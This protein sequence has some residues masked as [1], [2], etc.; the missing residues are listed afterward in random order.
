MCSLRSFSL[1]RLSVPEHELRLPPPPLLLPQQRWRDA[2]GMGNPSRWGSGE[3]PHTAKAMG[4]LW[5]WSELDWEDLQL[6][7]EKCN[8]DHLWVMDTY[9]AHQGAWRLP[10]LSET[11]AS[12]ICS[13]ML[14][15][16]LIKFV[17]HSVSN[18]FFF[19][20][21]FS[22][23]QHVLGF[24]MTLLHMCLSV[25]ACAETFSVIAYSVILLY[26]AASSN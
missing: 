17:C 18:W 20:F 11:K 12:T 16:I 9:R 23:L 22:H 14:H 10:I 2:A 6:T 19:P 5:C 7:L 13:I 8:K 3:V 4:C 15:W 26:R 24:F 1:A 21:L 25:L